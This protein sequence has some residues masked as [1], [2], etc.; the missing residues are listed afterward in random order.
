MG[1]YKLDFD[2]QKLEAEAWA[3]A[4]NE[5]GEKTQKAFVPIIQTLAAISIILNFIVFVG[6]FCHKNKMRYNGLYKTLE[7][8]LL[9]EVL[10]H[11]CFLIG[12]P[13]KFE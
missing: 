8:L 3:A 2:S 13:K 10:T 7:A 12:Y 1:K 11:L 6:V 9:F 5:V 4:A